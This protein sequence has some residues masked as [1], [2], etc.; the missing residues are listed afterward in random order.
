M[1][2]EFD[3]P[4]TEAEQLEQAAQLEEAEQ[5]AFWPD[6]QQYLQIGICTSKITDALVKLFGEEQIQLEVQLTNLY[7]GE[8]KLND[9][10]F[11][12]NIIFSELGFSNK[13]FKIPLR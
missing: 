10:I 12:G 2:V 6:R 4:C 3:L 13:L 1:Q 11:P 9:I 8:I 5:G 7:Q